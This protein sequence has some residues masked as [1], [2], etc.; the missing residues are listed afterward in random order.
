MENTLAFSCARL[1]LSTW[2]LVDSSTRRLRQYETMKRSQRKQPERSTSRNAPR[3]AGL[4]VV[5]LAIVAVIR[6][7]TPQAPEVP[8]VDRSQLEPDVAHKI[9]NFRES[10]ENAPSSHEAWGDLGVVFHAHGLEREAALCYQ[11]ALELDPSD[12]RWHYLLVHALLDFDRAAAMEESARAL[13]VR[14]DY[15]ALLVLRAELFEESDAMDEAKALYTRAL[16]LDPRDSSAELALG[17]LTM[18]EGDLEKARAHLE[19]ASELSP[20]AGSI[21]AALARLYRRLGENDRAIEAA[22]RVM[23]SAASIPIADPLHIQMLRESVSSTAQLGHAEDFA[24]AGDLKQAESIYRHLVALRPDDAAMRVRLGDILLQQDKNPE[25]KVHYRAALAIKGDDAAG[26]AGLAAVLGREG[27]YDKAV[28]HFQESLVRR[29]DHVPTLVSLASVLAFQGHTDKA[30][31]HYD[32]ALEL[33]SDNVSARRSLAEFMFRLK[34][35]REAAAHY[36]KVLQVEPELGVVHLQL[37]AAL[38]VTGE[39]ADALSH[40]ERARDLGQTVPDAVRERVEIGLQER[41]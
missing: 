21:Y 27:A 2:C 15:P 3:I 30:M 11:K 17:R 13:E 36:R 29:S 39:Y 22:A 34:R 10:V 41:K 31:T 1:V 4:V 24:E 6:F 8:D 26:H 40:L 9:Q 35:Y 38:A 37:G 19:R 20:D 23:S 7:A 33:E 12:F 14:S 32:H 5:G 25:A 28:S 16:E 18:G